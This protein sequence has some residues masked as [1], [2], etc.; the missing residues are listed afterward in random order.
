MTWQTQT[1]PNPRGVCVWMAEV[2]TEWPCAELDW[3]NEVLTSDFMVPN[4]PTRWH[5]EVSSRPGAEA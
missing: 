4:R 1:G 2:G 3:T 5:R